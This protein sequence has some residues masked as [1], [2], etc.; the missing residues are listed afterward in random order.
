[1]VD[2]ATEDQVVNPRTILPIG[3]SR[4]RASGNQQEDCKVST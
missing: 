3:L 1:M 2:V 4:G